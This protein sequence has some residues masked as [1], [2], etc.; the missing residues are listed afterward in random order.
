MASRYWIG[1]TGS[2]SNTA[3]WSVSSG[4][5]GGVAIPTS[6][7]DVFIDSS[8]GFGSG[9]TITL[10]GGGTG[11]HDFTS[12]SGHTYTIDGI[13][14]TIALDCY[15]DLTLEAGI[16]FNTILT[17]GSEE[18][19]NITTA[20]VVI[21]TIVGY[22]SISFNGGGTYVIQDNL[23]LTGQFYLESGTFDANNHNITADNFYFFADTGL[24]PTV[25][26]GSGIWEVTGCGDAWKVSENNG[27]VVTITPETSTIKLTDT[28]VENKTFTGA[29]KTY[30]N[31]W[32]NVGSGS[33]DVLIYGSNTFND[34]KIDANVYA[35]FSGGTTQTL[36]TFSP[37]GYA[38]N[39]VILDNIEGLGIQFNLSKTSG[40]VSCDH[41]D[42]SNSNAIG[43]A[44][45][46]AGTHSVDT[47]NRLSYPFNSS[48]F[49]SIF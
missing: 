24:T 39:L 20:G 14:N 42:I 27:E 12:I 47:T 16:T 43:G 35:R 40:I 1:G 46:Y 48:R 33:G 45:W 8:S 37:Q 38:D 17:F 22:P 11:F 31:L 19:C 26:M 28:T 44:T 32:I 23:E 10:D 25:V 3:H 13:T 36:N 4:G 2:W 41:L 9:G 34:L 29:G 15:G 6:S 49:F 21:Q 7:D 18:I 30:N 5:A